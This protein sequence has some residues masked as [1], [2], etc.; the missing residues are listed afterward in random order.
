MT[1]SFWSKARARYPLSQENALNLE[2]TSGQERSRA[3]FR[4]FTEREIVPYAGL[5]DQQ[6]QVPAAFFARLAA[7]GYLGAVLRRGGEAMDA[8]TFGLL[9]EE[10]GRGCSSVRS[11]ITVHSM[12]GQAILRWGTPEQRRWWGP[13]LAEGSKIGAFCLTEPTAGSDSQSIQATARRSGD[14]YILNGCKQWIT[15][16]QVAAI[17]LVFARFE[18]TPCAFIVERGSPG[19]SIRPV[20]GMLGLRAAMLAEL[21]LEDCRIPGDHLIGR[22]GFGI[23]HIAAFALDLGR[24]SVA[25]GCVGIAQACLEASVQYAEERRQFGGFLAEHQL[26]QQMLTQLIVDTEAARLLCCQAGYMRDNAR[27]SS[28][29][30]TS[31]AKYFASKVANRAATN[32]VQIHG[33]NGCS[34]RYPVERFLR[35]SKIMAI[36]EGSDQ[37]QEIMIARDYRPEST[38]INAAVSLQ[39]A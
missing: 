31:M 14:E 8:I 32:A 20:N 36:I 39:R 21:H 7:A 3:E 25:W 15:F 1:R 19:A 10:I 17:F 29:T 12:V 22:S 35:D 30:H 11:L 18:D 33:A 38:K 23:S 6:G 26:V 34:S 24:Y 27:S 4:A 2:F 16:G 28:F 13:Q 5:W 9:N 37:M